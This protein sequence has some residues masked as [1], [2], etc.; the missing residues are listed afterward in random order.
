MAA[1]YLH[2]VETIRIDAGSSPVYTVDGAITAIVGTGMSGPVN[3]LT[4]YQIQ[5][6]SS[7][8]DWLVIM[9]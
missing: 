3:E 6:F 1:A 7:V 2:G 9:V 4:V 8:L 5:L